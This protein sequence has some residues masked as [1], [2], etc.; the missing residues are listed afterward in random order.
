MTVNI[1]VRRPPVLRLRWSRAAFQG[2]VMLVALVLVGTFTTS[3]FLSGANVKSMLLL[4]SFLGLASMGQTLCA[5]AG[6][7]DL[8]IPFV[9]GS[10]NIACLS[11]IGHGMPSALAV[12]IVVT[13]GGLIGAINGILSQVIP[14]QALV[15]TL[16]V[17]FAA[18]GGT[19]ILTSLGT[20]YG[21]VVVATVPDWLLNLASLDGTTAGVP[22]P[23]IIAV[24]IVAS[25]LMLMTLRSTWFGRGL[26]ALGGNRTAAELMLVSTRRKW[27]ACFALSGMFSAA[28]GVVLLGFTGGGFVGI[29]DPYLFTTIAAVAVGGTS[30]AGGQGGYANTILGTLVLTL[31]TS[32]LVG[33]GLGASAQQVVMGL[34][35]IIIV[36]TYTRKEPLRYRI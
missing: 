16:G 19:Q 7:I 18:V 15:V 17:G 4:A 20:S 3:G 26:Y 31:L 22:L 29:G 33:Y 1:A 9:I 28:T 23:P 12:L 2:P 13:I 8:S 34:L 36:A 21:G 11:L 10:A 27:T 35:I 32:V 30:L 6:G 24:W 5:L 25:A 14:A